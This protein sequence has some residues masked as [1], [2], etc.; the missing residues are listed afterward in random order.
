MVPLLVFGSSLQLLV[1]VQ[2]SRYVDNLTVN[3]YEYLKINGHSLSASTTPNL[4]LA[5]TVTAFHLASS[6]LIIGDEETQEWAALYS[7][8][9][10]M[11][12]NGSLQ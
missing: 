4:I 11:Y 12:L 9:Y 5:P 7:T 10:F 6:R 8:V 2:V 1:L 3:M